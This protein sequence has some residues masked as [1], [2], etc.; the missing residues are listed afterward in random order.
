MPG[1]RSS[2]RNP[3]GGLYLNPSMTRK[4]FFRMLNI[5]IHVNGPYSVWLRGADI[6]LTPTEDPLESGH[7]D[8]VCNF[9][10]GMILV[11]DDRC[12][13]RSFSAT[14]SKRDRRFREKVRHRDRKCVITGLRICSYFPFSQEE[15]FIRLNYSQYLTNTYEETGTGINSCQNGL[16]MRSTVHKQFDSYNF[17]IDPDDDYKMTC[18]AEDIDGVDGR[19]LDPVC[20]DPRDEN[21]VVDEFLRWHFRQAVLANMKG[22][23][24]PIFESDFPDGSDMVGEILSGPRASERMEA[25]LFSRLNSV[26]PIP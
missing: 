9:P 3:L 15:L 6:P 13:V 17:A 7:Y 1:N 4:K 26:S 12:I 24:E 14:N 2:I 19:T 20:R 18:F 16:L 21:R 5:V 23:G 25:E 11:T 8:I 22:R 10:G